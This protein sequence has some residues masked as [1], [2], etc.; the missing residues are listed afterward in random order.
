[1]SRFEG[2]FRSGYHYLRI[3][4]HKLVLIMWVLVVAKSTLEGAFAV[5]VMIMAGG[6]FALVHYCGADESR[7]I[8]ARRKKL[9]SIRATKAGKR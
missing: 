3:A 7:K 6:C 2:V 9:M 8:L 5:F 1:M 4:I